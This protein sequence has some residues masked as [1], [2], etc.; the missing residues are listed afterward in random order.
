[1]EPLEGVQPVARFVERARV[2]ELVHA[3]EH[4]RRPLRAVRGGRPPG[5]GHEW[6]P[7]PLEREPAGPE[8]QPLPSAQGG[9]GYP[10]G[11]CGA[12]HLGKIERPIVDGKAGEQ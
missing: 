1:M 2:R 12:P 10:R 8:P 11:L 4:P 6:E 3:H 7:V 9:R 5:G